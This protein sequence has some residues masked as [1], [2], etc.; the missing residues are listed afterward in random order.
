MQDS[1]IGSSLLD[2]IHE[3]ARPHCANVLRCVLFGDV[4]HAA[5]GNR[6]LRTTGVFGRRGSEPFTCPFTAVCMRDITGMRSLLVSLDATA[7]APPDPAVLEAAAAAL[8]EAKAAAVGSAAVCADAASTSGGGGGGGPRARRRSNPA[9]TT[10]TTAPA[11]PAG[12]TTRLRA[13]EALRRKQNAAAEEEAPPPPADEAARV[14]TAG[15]VSSGDIGSGEESATPVPTEAAAATTTGGS[16]S[17][18]VVYVAGTSGRSLRPHISRPSRLADDSHWASGPAVRARDASPFAEPARQAARN[19][20]RKSMRTPDSDVDEEDDGG[21]AVREPVRDP[22]SEDEGGDDEEED[23]D[24]DSASALSDGA[25]V[26]HVDAA[27]MTVHGMVIRTDAEYAQFGVVYMSS[28]GMA[29]VPTTVAPGMFAAAEGGR[30]DVYY[31]VATEASAT[32]TAAAG[33]FLGTGAAQDDDAVPAM[34]PPARSALD[35]IGFFSPKLEQ[36]MASVAQPTGSILYDDL[37]AIP[38]EGGG[39]RGAYAQPSSPWLAHADAMGTAMDISGVT[40]GPQP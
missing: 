5:S 34:F 22:G 17:G 3:T 1:L 20:R 12:R 37:N 26:G 30:S 40:T 9:A 14:A 27:Q 7:V 2:L 32:T 28:E 6:P 11:A 25:W 21:T 18:D 13:A 16:A 35:A 15:D 38:P 31:A 8:A 29:G 39:W 24:E 4:H 19:L 10:S 23:E 33:P 36:S